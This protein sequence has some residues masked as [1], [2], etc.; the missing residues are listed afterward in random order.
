MSCFIVLFGVLCIGLE[1]E[2]AWISA[3]ALHINF[4]SSCCLAPDRSNTRPSELGIVGNR[5]YV[6]VP[7]MRRHHEPCAQA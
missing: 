4:A 1:D 3:H 7:A 2:V 5:C 6:D